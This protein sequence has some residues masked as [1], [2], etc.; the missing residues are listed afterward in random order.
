M[1]ILIFG[2]GAVGSVVGGFLA[3]TG[4]SVSLLG[5][6]W[7]LDVI[8]KQGLLITGIWGD[9]RIK[10]FELYRGVE[11]F[12]KKDTSFDLIILTVK[13]YD[14][15]NSVKELL[16]MMTEKTMLLS[17]QNGLGNIET[18]L[19]TGIRPESFL[20]GRVIFGADVAPGVVKVTVNADSVRIGGLPGVTTKAGAFEI[21]RVF[22][23]A[24]IPAEAVPDIVT[25]LWAKAIYNCALNAI[26]SLH[27]IPYGKILESEE[28]RHAMER[29]IRECYEV[30]L[31]KRMTLAPSSAD[32]FID[33][34]VQKLIPSTAAHFPSMLRDLQRGKRTEID[35]LNGAIYRY[36]RELG[37]PTPENE[38]LVN[39][40]KLAHEKFAKNF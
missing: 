37:V 36:G 2:A 6:P 15:E 34:M 21:A 26:C 8:E 31:K 33:L 27:E 22:N 32:A 25:V 23:A 14:T 4:H 17:L 11:D 13:S 1:K 39:Q 30:A 20:A 5:R 24:K 7:H 38:S 10:A 40:L 12:R 9:Y 29:V 16:P 19:A 3:R 18:I 35:S 28:T